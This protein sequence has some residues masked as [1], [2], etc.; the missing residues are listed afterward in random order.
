VGVD[1]EESSEESFGERRE[2]PE[3]GFDRSLVLEELKSSPSGDVSPRPALRILLRRLVFDAERAR[4]GE[5]TGSSSVFFAESR[6]AAAFPLDRSPPPLFLAIAL[7][8]RRSRY[9]STL[10]LTARSG[11]SRTGS[12]PP[13]AGASKSPFKRDH[14]SFTG[15][16]SRTASRS[17]SP[18]DHHCDP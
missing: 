5:Y 9:A 7:L 13:D 18:S 15:A 3:D 10:R 1:S 16:S 12:A 6:R 14:A 17:S 4:A 8:R 2:D 11:R